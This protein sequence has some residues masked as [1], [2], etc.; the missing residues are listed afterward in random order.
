MNLRYVK[1][2]DTVEL[3]NNI[4]QRE[5]LTVNRVDRDDKIKGMEKVGGLALEDEAGVLHWFSW[6]ALVERGALRI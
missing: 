5:R 1:I 6:A 4:G 3:K 2:G